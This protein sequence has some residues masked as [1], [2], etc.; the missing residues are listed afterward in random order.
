MLKSEFKILVNSLVSQADELL[1]GTPDYQAGY[2]LLRN[3]EIF[4]STHHK[5]LTNCYVLEHK[6]EI[7]DELI[8]MR[9]CINYS[10]KRDKWKS[11]MKNI[12]GDIESMLIQNSYSAKVD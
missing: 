3:F 4:V 12:K 1:A 6:E 10:L 11:V 2:L 5:H 9:D 7:A 8:E